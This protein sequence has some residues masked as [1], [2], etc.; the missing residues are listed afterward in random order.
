MQIKY[1]S[2]I[3][4]PFCYIGITHV[5]AALKEVGAAETPVTL[6]SYQLNPQAPTQA[7]MVPKGMAQDHAA[8]IE[9]MASQAGLAMNLAEVVPVNSLD[10]HRLIKFAQATA[11]SE[12]VEQLIDQLYRLYFTDN[13]VISNPDILTQAATEVGLDQAAA[14]QVLKSDQYKDAVLNDEQA[15]ANSGV[16]GVPFF[17]INDEYGISGA[18]PVEVLADAFKQIL[19]AEKSENND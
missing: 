3:A 1:W 2:D 15:A 4:C 17:V 11:T 9:Q 19:Q 12:Q 8:Q 13:A 7:W 14:E 10:A 18:Q 5:K 6:M 16:Q